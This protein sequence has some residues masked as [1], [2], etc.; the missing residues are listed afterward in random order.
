[1]SGEPDYFLDL[2]T[3]GHP[4]APEPSV[5]V[6][7]CGPVE[8]R[9]WIGVRFECCGVYQ[10]IYRSADGLLYAG[11]CPKCAKAMRVRVGPGGT[12]DRFFLAT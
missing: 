6:P 1:M 12:H 7:N 5:T 4:S 3:R 10:R 8:S 9:A 11:R 2:R